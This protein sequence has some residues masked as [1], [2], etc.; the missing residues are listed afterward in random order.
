MQECSFTNI[1]NEYT[2]KPESHSKEPQTCR[3]L[4]LPAGF[5]SFCSKVCG[6]DHVRTLDAVTKSKKS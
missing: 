6:F 2:R 3:V 1:L 4:V 5:K